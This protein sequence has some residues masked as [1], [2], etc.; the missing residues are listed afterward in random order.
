MK[1]ISPSAFFEITN[2]SPAE[3]FISPTSSMCTEIR[4]RP[5]GTRI[6]KIY[7]LTRLWER[8]LAMVHAGR[9]PSRKFARGDLLRKWW[10]HDFGSI[11][12]KGE[13]IFRTIDYCD[14]A[15]KR[16]SEDPARTVRV[17]TTSRRN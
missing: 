15:C 2:E 5:S 14:A 1:E 12:F 6:Q 16:G 13:R 7:T 3:G 10:G 8:S 9:T 17:L 11:E 4:R